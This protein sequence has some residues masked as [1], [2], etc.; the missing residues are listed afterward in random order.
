MY[1]R[2]AKSGALKQMGAVRCPA[3]SAEWSPD[4]EASKVEIWQ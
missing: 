2:K 3:V 4:G 1:D